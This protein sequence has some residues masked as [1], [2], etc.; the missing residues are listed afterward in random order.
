MVKVG[1]IS[2]SESNK[3]CWELKDL[4]AAKQGKG[5]FKDIGP[6]EIIGCVTCSAFSGKKMM[7]GANLLSKWGA[8]IIAVASETGKSGPDNDLFYDRI[9]KELTKRLKSTIILDCRNGV[10]A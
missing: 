6:A 3:D 7:D 5:L 8:D 1:I 9:L 10:G 2:C 4:D